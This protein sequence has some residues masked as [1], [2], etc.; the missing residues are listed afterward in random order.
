MSGHENIVNI[1]KVFLAS[2]R[3]LYITFEFM[4]TDLSHVVKAKLLT[5]VHVK[6]IAYQLLRALKYIHSAELLHRDVKPSN[7]LIDD[8]CYIKICD[9]GLCRSIDETFGNLELTD[10]VMTRW[11][12]APGRNF[13]D[14]SL[15]HTLTSYLSPKANKHSCVNFLSLSYNHRGIS[16]KQEVHKGCR[17]VVSGMYYW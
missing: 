6:F 17:L 16:R 5:D 10:Y 8:S 12:R 7:I 15:R 1:Q 13:L 14:L 2:G 3:D 9:F 11:Y 4:Q